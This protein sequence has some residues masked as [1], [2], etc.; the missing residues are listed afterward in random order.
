MTTVVFDKTGT[1]THGRPSV[2]S[3]SVLA[4]EETIS[5]PRLLAVACA[6][7]SGSEHPLAAAIVAYV[8]KVMGE[9]AEVKAKIRDFQAVP[10]CG[11]RVAVSDLEPMV[12]AL[13]EAE[14][15]N[16]YVNLRKALPQE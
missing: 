1:I 4:T 7:E 15:F 11:L 6:A 14:E 12:Q 8:R 3:V 2:A 10:G 9:G 16:N 13:E 5:L